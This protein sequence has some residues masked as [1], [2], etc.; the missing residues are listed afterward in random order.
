MLLKHVEFF[1]F[2]LMFH[3]VWKCD[4]SMAFEICVNVLNFGKI[5]SWK[6]Q[7]YYCVSFQKMTYNTGN[8]I[9]E[10]QFNHCMN[11]VLIEC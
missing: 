5:R 11:L 8:Y 10:I 7:L 9:L 3:E 2:P 4:N 1:I 6:S